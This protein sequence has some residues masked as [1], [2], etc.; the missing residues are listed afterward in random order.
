[1]ANKQLMIVLSNAAEGRDKEYNDWYTN[2]HLRDVLKVPGMVAAQRYKLGS[3]QL[4]SAA[5]A[6]WQYLAVYE[7]E[8]DDPAATMAEIGKRARTPAMPVPDVV[9]DN[10]AFTYE[11]ITGR[12][13]K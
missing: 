3:S 7:M 11:P 8:T 5:K 10:F 4:A 6:Q 13:E 9:K 12:V 1:M 2:V